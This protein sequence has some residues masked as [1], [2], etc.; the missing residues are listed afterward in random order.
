M[1]AREP[2]PAISEIQDRLLAIFPEATVDRTYLTSI[3][4]ART[5]FV[6]LYIN[7]VEGEDTWLTPKHV[8]KFPEKQIEYETVD[9]RHSYYV[10]CSKPKYEPKYRRWYADTTRESIRDEVLK[11]GLVAA[12]AVVVNDA[13]PTTSSKGRYALRKSFAEL[14]LA[15][16]D[17]V[18]AK[19]MYWQENFLSKSQRAKIAIS[20]NRSASAGNVTVR[21]PNGESRNLSPGESSLLAKEVVEIFA[22]SF[23]KEPEVLWISESSN[24]VAVQD[25][26]LMVSLGLP[27][28]Q[29]TLLPDMVLADLGHPDGALIVFVELVHS[30]GPMTEDRKCSLLSL[31]TEAGYKVS[32]FAFVTAFSSRNVSPLKKR[33][34]AIAVN[35]AIWFSCEPELLVWLGQGE[36]CPFQ[37]YKESA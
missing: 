32:N 33:F 30:D 16:E 1:F 8:Y 9:D 3:M 2:L 24:K 4:A 7:A 34:S 5:I 25:D 37:S 35:S 21:M 26:Q 18:A 31:V 27:I 11:D 10:A 12:G 20:Q 29:Q 23:L 13:I 15:A 19:L 28:D 17:D 22:N 14:F 36:P 6:M